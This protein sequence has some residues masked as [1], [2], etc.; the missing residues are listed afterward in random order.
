[1]VKCASDFRQINPPPPSP[2]QMLIQTLVSN[3]SI[4]PVADWI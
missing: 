4:V 1:M 2:P 3:L